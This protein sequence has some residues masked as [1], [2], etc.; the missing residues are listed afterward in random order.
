MFNRLVNLPKT[1]SFFLFGARTTGKTSL[2]KRHFSAMED[3]LFLD[4]LNDEILERYALAP[5]SLVREL[6]Q[7][8]RKPSWILI[9]EVQKEPRL[10]NVAH[11]LI[12]SKEK[13]KFAFTGSSARRLK[14]KGTNL[15][16]GRAFVRNLY[17]LS[18]LELEQSFVLE[19]VI[20]W[21]SLPK[22][23][24]FSDRNEK[25]DFLKA[26]ANTYIKS[27]IQEEQWVRKVI[28]FR[29]F[30]PIAAQMNGKPLNYT[31][32]ARDVGV[33]SPTVQTY[34]EI[35]EDTLLGFHLPAYHKSIRKQQRSAAKFYFVDLGVKKALQR[36]LNLALTPQ[37]AEWGFAFEHL[38]ICE[39]HWL[40]DYFGKN[41]EL[42]YLQTK[43]NFEIDL[44]VE[45]PGQRVAMVEIKSAD[46]IHPQQFS[47]LS[48]FVK[49]NKAE[50]F[51]LSNDPIE[52][53]H[54]KVAFLPWQKGLRT[55]LGI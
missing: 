13:Y 46:K 44:I 50:G 14:Q 19:E 38:V 10:L 39:A 9:D 34:F 26:Y 54:E 40:N 28:P 17:P 25:I 1:N 52:Q 35:L 15:L 48:A 3:V 51:V 23:Y 55:I 42:S 16:A 5:Q 53:S 33:E 20:N 32:I 4:L 30:L 6:E 11:Q 21:G 49:E 41:F 31:A 2:L 43:D 47:R 45:R 36:T 7:M 12:E 8:K 22:I 29:K 37:T 24:D 27:E 18:F